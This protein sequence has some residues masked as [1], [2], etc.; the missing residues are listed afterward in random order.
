MR[1]FQ[2]AYIGR[3]EFPKNL[4]EFELQQWFTFDERDRRGIRKAFRSRYWIGAA[5]HLGFLAM[6]GTT[7]RSIEYVPGILLRH[8][9]RQFVQ[10][11]PD[12]ATLRSLYRRS[13]TLYEH[14]RWAAEQWSLGKFTEDVE[15]RLAAY[16]AER[17]HATLSAN[18]LQQMA[19]EWLYRGYL[20]IPR[21][22]VITDLVR[23]VIHTVVHHDHAVLRKHR[24]E[25]RINACLQQLLEHRPGHS[26]THLEW[27]RR[28]PRRRSLKTLRELMEKY[29][30]LVQHVEGYLPLPIPKER[31]LV[32]ARRIGRRRASH[33]P[34]LP[35]FRQELETN[36]FAAVTLSALVDDILR[37]IQMRICAIWT[38]GYKIAADRVTPQRV[39]KRGE[40]LAELR[41]MA[42]DEKLTDTAFRKEASAILLPDLAAGPSSRAADVREV[43]TLNA[44]RIRPVLEALVKLDLRGTGPA[45]D[46]LDWLK[47]TYKEGV[48]QF[49]IDKAPAWARRWNTLIEDPDSGR[50]LRAY[51]AAT[52]GAVRQGLRNGSLYSFHGT[53]FSDPARHLMPQ[54]RWEARRG[55]YQLEKGL[56]RSPEQYTN[57]AQAALQASLAGLQDAVTA[58]DVWIG[59]KDLYFRRD[60]AAKQPEGV[61]LAQISL[62]RDI[63]RVQLP[64]LLLEL[65][66]RVRFSWKLLGREPKNPEE[67]LGVYGALLAAGTDLESR[68]VA[69]MIR[70]VHESTIRRYMRLLEAEPAMREANDALLQ[71]ARSHSIVNHWGTGFEASSD[72]M[73]LDASKHLYDA[74]VD[75]KRRVHGMGVYQTIL[76]QW[77][78]VYDQPLPLLRRQVGAAIEGVVRQRTAPIRW[79]AVD[80]HGHTHIG[81]AI[82]KLLGF[83]LYFRQN[84][85]R[86]QWL[87]LPR[88]WPE[89]PGLEPVLRRDLDLGLMHAEL[90][91]LLRVAAS[92]HD[93]YGSATYLLERMGSA[94][95]GSRLHR[96]GTQFGQLWGTVYLCDYA[97]QEPFRR[98][99]NGILVRG[100]S[101][102]QLERVIH[103]GP[104][105]SDRGRRGDEK[106]L[107][108]GALTLL[109]NAV[110]AYNTW[111]LHQVVERR[112]AAGK[113]VPAHDILAHISPIGF[114]HIN[115]HGV[116]RFPLERYLDRLMPSAV[117]PPLVVGA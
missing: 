71:F 104:I 34:R 108:S 83:D 109:T 43:L 40:I 58:G 105:R 56:P 111:K 8:L 54:A 85:M 102:H 68:G 51:E 80:T 69:R 33:I 35:T 59:R 50:S 78:I 24:G 17:T 75:P 23:I 95:S 29:Q 21:R 96:A 36:C 114:R 48:S 20:E 5:L 6:T 116:Y 64:T 98:S 88:D 93:G 57:R 67:L 41:K 30:W 13:Q 37:L 117:S 84:D 45:R 14:Q 32:Y 25:V 2:A 28:P 22:R 81:L 7:L 61:E 115:F 9:G 39:H 31:Q 91:E 74:R 99:V 15:K 101:V 82:A 103:T 19:Y 12:L 76:A 106:V 90:D 79:L 52:L 49:L 63:G 53:E 73:S 97:A 42:A 38:W 65:D 112:R 94:A 77:G 62:Y 11:A 100:E 27:L 47:D 110:I 16:L 44:R 1:A 86:H 70:G 46:G 113:P 18:R 60:E 10:K 72:L 66:A 55:S 92:I 89:V 4:S 87:H 3:H 107:I 26:M